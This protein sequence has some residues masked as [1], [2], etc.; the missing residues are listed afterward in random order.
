M[1]E[2]EGECVCQSYLR[3]IE[4]NDVGEEHERGEEIYQG[5]TT[6]P[7]VHQTPHQVADGAR[8][9]KIKDIQCSHATRVEFSGGELEYCIDRSG[10]K[11][12][13]IEA[14]EHL[15]NEDEVEGKAPP[16]REK[17]KAQ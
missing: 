14:M 8:H 13:K 9:G 5:D 7:L 15:D 16:W 12:G 11:E 6:C 10:P 4:P 2:R 3:P 1:Y 17:R